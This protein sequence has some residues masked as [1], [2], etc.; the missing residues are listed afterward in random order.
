VGSRLSLMRQ[1]RM[2]FADQDRALRA[3]ALAEASRTAAPALRTLY[4][5]AAADVAPLA[6]KPRQ[7]LHRARTPGT[8]GDVA[9]T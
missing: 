6:G 9:S 3:S 7:A 4:T 5:K 8:A 2:L 1:L